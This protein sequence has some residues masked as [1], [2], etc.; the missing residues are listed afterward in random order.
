MSPVVEA[1]TYPAH[2]LPMPRITES[3]LLLVSK[4]NQETLK[5]FAHGAQLTKR[6]GKSIRELQL[7]VAADRIKLAS[8]HLR[9]ASVAS[10]AK[11]PQHR[12]TVSRAYYAMYHAARAATYLSIGGDDHE[13]HSVLPTKLPVDFPDCDEW[14]N[15]LKIARL[16]R[17]R[18]DYDPYPTG[19]SNFSNSAEELLQNAR[20]LVKLARAYLQSKI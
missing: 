18:A 1:S 6:A 14:K 5:G 13:Q 7:R 2:N 3:E 10:R 16:E 12:T 17:N 20:M 8:L 9:Q 11:V 4:S 15:R 19:D